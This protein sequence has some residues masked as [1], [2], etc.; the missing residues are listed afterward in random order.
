MWYSAKAAYQAGCD[1]LGVEYGYQANRTDL[2]SDMVEALI[3]ESAQAIQ[4]QIIGRYNQ[5]ILIGKSLGTIVL[6]KVLER[7]S[8]PVTRQIFL[9]PLER[10]IPDILAARN[11]L[12][13]AGDA[14]SAL[15]PT[16]VAQIKQL[17]NVKL[18][19]FPRAN[20]A[21][22]TEDLFESLDILKQ[23]AKLCY[24]FCKEVT[25]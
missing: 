4:Q 3:D 7:V 24:D 16:A 20:H 13:V 10:V 23:T 6:T 9:T 5:A 15:G 25:H 17:S 8:L 18:T 1:V 19:L 2:H 14:D 11:A 12:V 22:E 21:L